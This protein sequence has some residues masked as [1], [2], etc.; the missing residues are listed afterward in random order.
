MI[1]HAHNAE[2]NMP[3]LRQVIRT[4]LL[5]LLAV[6][7]MSCRGQMEKSAPDVAVIEKHQVA[8]A[9][10]TMGTTYHVTVVR[11][12]MTKEAFDETAGKIKSALDEVDKKMST[13]LPDS[14]LSRFNR[15]GLGKPV[16][17]SPDTFFVVQKA[18]EIARLSGGAFD[19]TVLPLVE[20]WGFAGAK[21][22]SKPP[23]AE[24]LDRA[25]ALVDYRNVLLE[26]KTRAL[27]KKKAGVRVDLA[28]IAKGFAADKVHEVLSAEGNE[29]FMVE[30]GGDYRN[31]QILDEKRIS[32][33]IDPRLSRPVGHRLASVSVITRTCA[34][35]D[36]L[37]TAA[38]VLGPEDGLAFLAGIEGVEGFLV[39]RQKDGGFKETMTP[40]FGR[41]VVQKD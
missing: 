19:P 28:G 26:R 9:G 23:S 12:P 1:P 41:F 13:F 32:H 20:A 17:V 2:R 21:P 38:D 27:S 30:I 31:F 24:A 29:N 25:S 18:L 33:T 36:A 8:F 7:A 3:T 4:F 16:R 35:A 11:P 5:A 37:A 14:E 39:T 10:Q 40:G 15:A 34:D 6:A 22:L